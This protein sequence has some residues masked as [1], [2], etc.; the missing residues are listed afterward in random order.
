MEALPALS[1]AREVAV[2]GLGV[3]SLAAYATDGQ[4][5][6]FYEIDPAVENIARRPE[7]F[8]HL[9]DCG[10]RCRVVIGDARL[11]L[12]RTEEHYDVLVLDAFSS[13]AIPVHLVTG[14]AISVYLNR[15]TP[16][17]VLAFHISNRHLNLS[18]VLARLAADA[19]LTLLEQRHVVTPEEEAR[20]R[21][22]SHW[23]LMTRAPRTLDPLLEDSRWSHAEELS[24]QPWT[25]DFSNI[26]SVLR[27]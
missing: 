4:R 22:S 2:I 16:D 19:G 9:R 17:G 11:S 23:I 25:D 13:D 6:T 5:W 24:S 21:S 15:L 18:P 10:Q 7:Y 12:A 1:R 27:F 3:G 26:L 8:T 14:E 20:G